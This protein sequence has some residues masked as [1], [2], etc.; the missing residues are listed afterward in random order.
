M[1]EQMDIY[2]E[3]KALTGRTTA[4]KKPKADGEFCLIVHVLVQN[5]DGL[6]LITKRADIGYLPNLWEN[7]GGAVKIGETS[8][9]AAKR[10]FHEET[11]FTLLPER[12][13]LLFTLKKVN[14]GFSCFMDNWF[15]RQDFDIE[16]FL[17]QDGETTAAKWASYDEILNLHKNGEFV[18]FSETGIDGYFRRLGF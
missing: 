2:D 9:E 17:P 15:F 18:P 13:K 11:G 12:G 8:L 16:N 3:N 4:H 14:S 5:S 7:T 6:F 1:D 10:E